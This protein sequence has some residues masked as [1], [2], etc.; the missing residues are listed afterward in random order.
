MPRRKKQDRDGLHQRPNSPYWWA[1]IPNGR[2]GSARRSTRVPIAEDPQGLK[3]AAVRA[4]W[5]AEAP[6]R[7]H[8]PTKVD[9]PTFDDLLLAYLREVTPRK[10]APE[11]DTYSARRLFP[12]FTG[13]ALSA[14]NA[15]EVR[16]YIAQR[17]HDGA[18]AGTLNKEIGL[19]S[20]A[21]NW[22]RRELELDINN[23]WQSRRQRE[24]AGRTRW[25]TREQVEALIGAA[26]SGRAAAHLPAFVGLCVHAGLRPGEAL[27]L[28]WARVD[29][30]R[31]RIVLDAEDSKSGE[32]AEVPINA[33]ARAALLERARFR[34]A[35]CPASPWVFCR[36][37]GSRIESIK[38]GFAVAARRAGLTDVHPHDLRRTCGSWLVQAGVGI[39]R[40]SA[41]LRHSDVRVTARVYAHLRPQ[42][43]ADALAT[44]D[45]PG[46]RY[47]SSHSEFTLDAETKKATSDDSASG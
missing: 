43:L 34:A 19:A 17:Q 38:H 28:E 14:I 45:Q 30:P 35:H 39:E 4:R 20:A 10:R 18:S 33:G 15:P 31:S 44:L 16:G 23:P 21:W 26:R 6:H 32:P 24:P 25:L 37:D 1:S 2:G 13:K 5:I 7:A 40:V 29:L 8:D 9:A 41:I 46:N 3:A 22:G 36:K 12:Y 47:T 27:T 11:R 42:D